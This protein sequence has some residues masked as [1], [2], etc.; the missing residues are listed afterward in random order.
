[1]KTLSPKIRLK[2]K[3]NRI[4]LVCTSFDDIMYKNLEQNQKFYE[5]SYLRYIEKN[6]SSLFEDITNLVILDVGANIGN[7]TVFF[8]KIMNARVFAF[9]PLKEAYDILC[10][11]IELNG[12]EDYVVAR[13]IG[14]SA[15]NKNI[16]I[17]KSVKNMC[18]STEWWYDSQGTVRSFTIDHLFQDK[19]DLIKID[20]QGMEIEVLKGAKRIIKRFS[21][22]IMI[23][24]PKLGGV[25]I[26]HEEFEHWMNENNYEYVDSNNETFK[27]TTYLIRRIK[28]ENLCDK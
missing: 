10:K 20:V 19:I 15:T 26:N 2:Y 24:I 16:N 18:G 12:I 4:D 25:Q 28:D 7:H 11:N 23:D 9:E 13:Q 22:I 14:I 27:N 3:G 8:S 17:V 1:M 21:P 6:E 5:M